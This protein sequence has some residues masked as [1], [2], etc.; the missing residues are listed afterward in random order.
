MA[1][2]ERLKEA[3]EMVEVVYDLGMVPAFFTYKASFPDG[4]KDSNLKISKLLAANC[5]MK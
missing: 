5:S 3:G 4:I 1:Y 2:V